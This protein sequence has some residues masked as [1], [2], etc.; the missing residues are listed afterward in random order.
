MSKTLLKAVRKLRVAIG[1]TQQQFANRLGLAISTIVRYELSRSPHGKVLIQFEK[2][3]LEHGQVDLAKVF[4]QALE[5]EL[6]LKEP[7][8]E[9][10]S[11]RLRTIALCRDL[12]RVL[13]KYEMTLDDLARLLQ[14]GQLVQGPTA[15][16][17]E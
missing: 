12:M 7:T 16:G 2:L 5:Y 4:R 17:E 3:A 15:G 6:G 1:D 10:P 13:M 11:G 9:I 14:S 8:G